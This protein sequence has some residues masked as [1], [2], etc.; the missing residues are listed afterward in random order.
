[1]ST[2]RQRDYLLLGL[3]I[4]LGL[5]ARIVYLRMFGIIYDDA[6]ITYRYAFNLIHGHGF[7]YNPGEPTFGSSSPLYTMI[8]ACCAWLA[9]PDLLPEISRWIGFLGLTVMVILFWKHLPWTP[10]ARCVVALGLLAYPRIFYSSIGGMEEGFTLGLMGLSFVALAKRSEVLLGIAAGA[11]ILTKVDT[12]VWV[13]AIVGVATIMERRFP[14]R[15]CA[16]GAAIVVP[17]FLYSGLTFGTIV[18]ATVEAKRIAYVHDIHPRV[19]DLF[20]MN[21]PDA[22]RS[23]IPVVI[24]FGLLTYGLIATTMVLAVRARAWMVTLFPIY[25]VLYALLLLSSG[26]AVGLWTR[27]TVPL[28]AAL[29]VCAGYVVHEWSVR[30]GRREA[31]PPGLR[32]V[33]I[34]TAVSLI[35]L[36]SS[37][38]YPNRK[39]LEPDSFRA[40]GEY[41]RASA[42]R[43]DSVMLE[44]IGL[45]G[46]VS[47]LYVHDF[48][49]LVTPAVVLARESAPGSDRWFMRYVV[50][51]RPAYVVLRDE[52]LRRNEF[53]F[54][55]YGDGI[56]RGMEKAWFEQY[57]A[58]VFAV[59]EGPPK[60][61]LIV[62]KRLHPLA[63][64]AG[65]SAP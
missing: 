31:P 18:P 39:G 28:W 7:A 22:Y 4:V 30:G 23:S 53:L 41:L 35:A 55:G 33:G 52:E 29:I 3:L 36:S 63:H 50:D 43:G 49:G 56:F 40:V 54:A 9:G 20:L 5:A 48:V 13:V 47:G 11:L 24:L 25:I 27:W 21:V 45:I 8:L 2:S 57:Y 1:V 62:F 17:W 16:L 44:P 46:Y 26:L 42:A 10:I 59:R 65:G 19:L 15:A 38:V 37:F 34:L 58:E 32:F 14:W 51:H 61:Q 64:T 12:F 60:D 6:Y